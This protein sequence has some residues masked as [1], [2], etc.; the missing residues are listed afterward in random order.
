MLFQMPKCADD[1][2][3]E[4]MNCI[5]RMLFR[6]RF[7]N[8]IQKYILIPIALKGSPST[9]I[10]PTTFAKY[11]ADEE[12]CDSTHE[13]KNEVVYI[14]LDQHDLDNIKKASKRH[15]VTVQ[16]TCQTAGN[17]AMCQMI[18]RG[19]KEK[20]IKVGDDRCKF[21]TYVAAVH[22]KRLPEQ[23]RDNYVVPHSYFISQQVR[24]SDWTDTD[25]FWKLATEIQEHNHGTLMSS[26]KKSYLETKMIGSYVTGGG[27]LPRDLQEGKFALLNY[28][29]RGDWNDINGDFDD[30][31]VVG[32]VGGVNMENKGTILSHYIT[33][34]NNKVVWSLSYATNSVKRPFAQSYLERCIEI[35][36]SY[37]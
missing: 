15:R 36:K 20:G 33:T 2:V 19:A 14:T 22:R 7:S 37:V 17:I 25:L 12:D 9:V 3:Y 10:K 16:S 34:M 23:E 35:L 4:D 30:L 24:L 1:Y 29:N 6:S 27:I 11:V 28:T 21:E 32:L 13:A 26:F 31:R 18:E 8:W 5:E